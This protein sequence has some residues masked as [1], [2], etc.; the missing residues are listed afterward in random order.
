MYFAMCC[1]EE[2]LSFDKQD[3]ADLK[4]AVKCLEHPGLTAQ[5]INV[6]G[7]PLGKA[8]EMLPA[9]VSERIS[10]VTRVAL[11][12]ALKVAL[13]TLTNRT[14]GASHTLHKVGIGVSGTVG[15]AFGLAALAWELPIS[16]TIML[17]SI[18]DIARSH[19]ENL[20]N[21]ET[22]LACLEVFALGSGSKRD[23]YADSEYFMVRSALAKSVAKAAEYL[24]AKGTRK[25]SAPVLVRFMSRVA[26]RFG[27]CV[28]EKVAA[29]LLPVVGAAGGAAINVLFMHH[30]QQI[31]HGH[32]T[33]RRLE[34][35]Y[36]P[37]TVREMYRAYLSTGAR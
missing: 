30:F 28:S 34:Q 31:A 32:F 2:K 12:K 10:G 21:M 14:G 17:R 6:A 9:G 35:K 27:L 13:F 37:A 16:T 25:M 33:V 4:A 7:L 11:D 5:I 15:G 29:Q 3:A 22:R 24:G 18:A 36:G 19:G 26:E 8:V 20:G 1:E 23:D